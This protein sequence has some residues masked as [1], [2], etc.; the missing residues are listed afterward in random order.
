ME[1]GIVGKPNAGK[2]TFFN[3]ATLSNAT[4]ANYPFTT[5]EANVGITFVKTKCVCREFGV[6]C[7]PKNSKCI[8]GYRF[9]PIKII[10]VA[11]LVP[12]AHKGRGLGNK[13]LDDIRKADVLIHVIDA[14]GSTDE[15]G[16]VY[17]PGSYDVTKDVIFLEREI[18]LWFFNIIKKHWEKILRKIKGENLDFVKYFTEKFS[19]LGVREEHVRK[20]LTMIK[21]DIYNFD[22][23]DLFEF[24]KTLREISKPIIIAA[25]KIDIDI[26]EENLKILKKRFPDKIIIPVSALA[27]YVLR[28]YDKERKIEYI[29]GESSFKILKK[30]SEKDMKILNFIE[31]NI[32]KKYK[33]T[34]VQDC[35]NVAV[36]DVLKKIVVYP[37]ENE[38]SLTDKHGNVLPDAFLMNKDATP[39]DLAYKIHSDL[40]KGFIAAIDIRT[41][42]RLSKEYKL[43]D[44]DVIKIYFKL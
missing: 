23:N 28:K 43:K 25:N 31:K 3:A 29:P 1:I 40:A 34:G 15:E 21:K 41:K 24:S 19:G 39:L 12:D 20:A 44:G 13:F 2:T 30:L 35:I 16:R 10:D 7:S 11:G 22:E 42:K 9:I 18:D 38:N 6:K 37:V 4:V 14:S 27:E 17:K 26:S 32:L 5:I 33:S 36:F 8:N